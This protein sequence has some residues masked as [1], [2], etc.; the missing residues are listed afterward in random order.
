MSP[1]PTPRFIVFAATLL[2]AAAALYTL[3]VA[4]LAATA[5]RVLGAWLVESTECDA[6]VFTVCSPRITVAEVL[7]NGSIVASIPVYTPTSNPPCDKLHA[8]LVPTSNGW[9]VNIVEASGPLDAVRRVCRC[10]AHYG[11]LLRLHKATLEVRVGWW[12]WS[13]TLTPASKVSHR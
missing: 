2:L 6:I 12:R 8:T 4:Y 5:P 7:V 1:M 10:A 11:Y 9:Y 3:L 13:T